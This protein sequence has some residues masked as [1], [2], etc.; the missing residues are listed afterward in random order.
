MK[1]TKLKSLRASFLGG[2]ALTLGLA[3]S[4]CHTTVVQPA[5]QTPSSAQSSPSPA[6]NQST[7]S[8]N[9]RNSA[10]GTTAGA[11]TNGGYVPNARQQPSP[12]QA[13][14]SAANTSKGGSGGYVPR[15]RKP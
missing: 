10:S 2:L 9:N 3:F 11:G 8:I 13:N 5:G 6:Q 7:T 14:S 12:P 4:G 15:S 1:K